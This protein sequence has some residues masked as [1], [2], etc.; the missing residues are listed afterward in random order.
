M[1]SY[2]DGL[3]FEVC[4]CLIPPSEIFASEKTGLL[5][6][7]V[8]DRSDVGLSKAYLQVSNAVGLMDLRAGAEVCNGHNLLEQHT[9]LQE[10]AVPLTH[11]RLRIIL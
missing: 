11:R 6:S 1:C 10:F 2:L 7:I 4:Q 5:H 3:T 9:A 8:T